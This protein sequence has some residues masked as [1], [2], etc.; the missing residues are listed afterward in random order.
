MQLVLASL[1]TTELCRSIPLGPACLKSVLDPALGK[2][3]TTSLVDIFP[4]ET[5]EVCV[6]RILALEP[7]YVGFSM[8]VW[9]RH[10]AIATANLL[11]ARRPDIV[12][13]AG[14]PE[15][16]ANPQGVAN[17]PAID[18]V[19]PG[20]GEELIVPFM[21][22]LLAGAPHD[23]IAKSILPHPV[24]DLSTLPSPYLNGL[25]DLTKYSSVLWEMSRGCA[26]KCAF[27]F[28]GRGTS[29]VRR[30]S[31]ERLKAELALFEKHHVSQVFVLDPT[32]NW[33]RR[34]AKEML[35]WIAETSLD[36]HFFFEVRTEFLDQELAELFASIRCTTQAGLQSAD[37][38]VLKNIHRTFNRD[39]FEAKVLLLHEAGV[40]YG[41][42][43]IYGLPG[44]TLQGF[45]ASLDFAM[46]LAP[47]HLD[48][49]RLS[50]LPGTELY[51]T[52]PG[53]GLVHMPEAPYS[54]ISSPTW[55]VADLAAAEDVA[56]GFSIFYNE[57]KAVPWYSLVAESLELTP[58]QFFVSVAQ[59]R[60]AHPETDP[61]ALQTAFLRHAFAEAGQEAEGR[62]ALDLVTYFG[63][64]ADMLLAA[65]HNPGNVQ[66]EAFNH[67]PAHLLEL[68][69]DGMT[70]LRE[71][72]AELA[73]EPCRAR[74]FLA[75]GDVGVERI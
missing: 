37:S 17:E 56:E 57:G 19:L 65:G 12:T 6:A 63:R 7:Q 8:Y 29:G 11:K 68:L 59:F 26:F 10:Q 54:V 74:L 43:L 70:S 36:M 31:K 24:H 41:F 16:T 25:L 38:A 67:D 66:I 45:L 60:K 61:F 23:E 48:I 39:D 53:F 47:N 30:F 13:F 42:D 1:Y 22:K 14:G 40:T 2:E 71:L 34:D 35:R 75:E 5:P 55:P 49:F 3:L 58:S 15:P 72:A 20:E 51:D 64:S 21:Q 27:C 46:G 28:E 62:V 4:H 52:A 50:V 18:F 32:F 73:P 33:N 69:Y 44:D 9:N